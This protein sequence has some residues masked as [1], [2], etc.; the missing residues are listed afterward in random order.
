MLMPNN[1][2]SEYSYHIQAKRPNGANV[3][4]NGQKIRPDPHPEETYRRHMRV[5]FGV[6]AF[7][8][9]FLGLAYVIV[10]Q[11]W[12]WRHRTFTKGASEAEQDDLGMK[13]KGASATMATSGLPALVQQSEQALQ[14]AEMSAREGDLQ[15]EAGNYTAAITAYTQALSAWPDLA[16]V[17][18]KLGRL[19]LRTQA[20]SRARYVLEKAAQLY[21]DDA[22]ILNDLGVAFFYLG[23]FDRAAA[24]FDAALALSADYAPAH[25]NRSLCRRAMSDETGAQSA[26]D[27]FLQLRPEDPRGLKEKAFFLAARRDYAGALELLNRAMAA[28]PRWPAAYFDAAAT[29]ALMNNATQ[30]IELLRKA[31]ELTSAATIYLALQQP[32]FSTIRTN[33]AVQTFQRDL[34]Q[35]A[36]VVR[37]GVS[38]MHK[39]GSPEPMVS[40]QQTVTP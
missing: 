17:Y 23:R 36:K 31:E 12:E 20:Y 15:V 37:E 3:L 18:P 38:S 10:V 21:P 24:Q 7:M 29:A 39:P 33:E 30:A 22:D 26:L 8:A 19:Y 13:D 35:R 34:L 32:A 27:S 5:F 25:F 2:P 1:R 14:R 6:I 28:A 40:F 16:A 4:P 11:T 9:A